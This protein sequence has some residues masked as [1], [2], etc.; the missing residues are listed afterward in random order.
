M[1][2]LPTKL[3]G[4]QDVEDPAARAKFEAKWGATIPP[5]NGWHLTEMFEAMARRELRGLFVIGEN[6]AQSEADV[7]HSIGLLRDLDHLVVQDIFLTKTAELAD[8]VLPGSASWCEAN[9]TV[10]NSERRVQLVRKALDPPG[11][12]RD[13]IEILLAIAANLGHE[14]TYGSAE[15]IWDELRSLSPMHAG[16]SYARLAELG[17]IQ[18]PCYSED[19]LE[20]SY[21]HGRLWADDPAD[22][23]RLAPFSVVVDDPPVDLLDD[24]FP[25]RLTT[26]RRLDSYNTGVQ[27]GG[28]QSPL[29]F[30]ETIDV[31]PEDAERLALH[32]NEMVRVVSRRGAVE[33]PVR[34]DDT[35]RPG[36]VFM[37][38]HFPDEIQTNLLTIDATDPKSGTAEFKAAAVRIDKIADRVPSAAD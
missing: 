38:F 22:R 20:P 34:I 36:L 7:D 23:G 21:L 12:A 30:G 18:W 10:T 26:G 32:D 16:M 6:P 13:D 14:W 2:A 17:G 31:S 27:S 3:P 4:F 25:L 37:T 5:E 8:V 29:R 1:G 11:D 35:L 19:R 33:A 9:G 28:F 15:E 24:E